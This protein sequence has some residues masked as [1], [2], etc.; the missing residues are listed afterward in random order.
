MVEKKEWH[1]EP[2]SLLDALNALCS[3][4]DSDIDE[5]QIVSWVETL[6]QNQYLTP[7]DLAEISAEEWSAMKLPLR[8]RSLGRLHLWH[9][10]GESSHGR[11]KTKK[12]S[13]SVSGVSSTQIRRSLKN[14]TISGDFKMPFP[15]TKSKRTLADS[16]GSGQHQSGGSSIKVST[17]TPS[18]PN[19]KIVRSK[20]EG[21]GTSGGTLEELSELFAP[22]NPIKATTKGIQKLMDLGSRGDSKEENIASICS[23]GIG[24]DPLCA[25]QLLK[26][27]S[28]QD[29][30]NPDPNK[31][32]LSSLSVCVYNE[33]VKLEILPFADNL[34]PPLVT[35]IVF[36]VINATSLN[37]ILLQFIPVLGKYSDPLLNLTFLV[38]LDANKRNFSDRKHVSV[39]QAEQALKNLRGLAYFEVVDSLDATQF[40]HLASRA[41][42]RNIKTLK[43]KNSN[44]LSK[45]ASL[46]KSCE[47]REALVEVYL[48][49]CKLEFLPNHIVQFRNTLT[50]LKLSH[51]QLRFFPEE[52]MLLDVLEELDL[53]DNLI[54]DLPQQVITHESLTKLDM[55]NNKIFQ[56]SFDFDQISKD[57]VIRL[58][59]NPVYSSIYSKRRKSS[60]ALSQPVLKPVR[61]KGECSIFGRDITEL[62]QFDVQENPHEKLYIPVFVRE[63]V[64][65]IL[66]NGLA[67]AGIFRNE[68]NPFQLADLRERLN[69]GEKIHFNRSD[70]TYG[71]CTLLKTWLKALPK[72]LLGSQ[73]NLSSALENNDSNFELLK[74]HLGTLNKVSYLTLAQLIRVL[75][76]IWLNRDLNM[77]DEETL[78]VGI[79]PC[80]VWNVTE[81]TPLDEIKLESA[82]KLVASMITNFPTLFENDSKYYAPPLTDRPKALGTLY[83]KLESR[84]AFLTSIAYI[85]VPRPPNR[86]NRLW[87]ADE[88]GTINIWN[89]TDFF[90]VRELEVGTE[91]NC[92]VT[93]EETVWVAT[94]DSI[95]TRNGMDGE[96]IQNFPIAAARLLCVNDT[97][98]A[99][100]PRSSGGVICLIDL[101]ELQ[102]KR[103]IPTASHLQDWIFL[104]DQV[105]IGFYD[106]S[107]KV[108]NDQGDVVT[109]VESK[110]KIDSLCYVNCVE[111]VW[112]IGES[113]TIIYNAINYE[114]VDRASLKNSI[115]ITVGDQIWAHRP[116]SDS[117]EIWDVQTKQSAGNICSFH[118]HAICQIVTD[119]KA[120]PSFVYSA[121]TNSLVVWELND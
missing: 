59:G 112:S 57:L 35:V 33:L 62:L 114:L 98:W 79:T 10:P 37:D 20:T 89:V 36:S 9:A 56:L 69:S 52:I 108:F 84:Q 101:D 2:S 107:L 106:G 55:E 63:V 25:D 77:M 40:I 75:H 105:W 80:L 109:D 21:G 83:R 30:T 115:A 41:F 45:L 39:E 54:I 49:R 99:Y 118:N 94:S 27:I 68:P 92:L 91:V 85:S 8:L 103:E 4:L 121:S 64:K 74:E 38:G 93:V 110:D 28:N 17:L 60:L 70:S 13:T 42:V 19:L 119:N 32:K 18:M 61:E 26:L 104:R 15:H 14:A 31:E 47:T 24:G 82:Q 58:K 96:L 90:L 86:Y 102:V 116:S 113:E 6:Q 12:H 111:Q 95:Q 34:E 71:V 100:Y 81:Q 87:S 73:E 7:D 1:P 48:K 53:S 3:L 16:D 117:V 120:K 51:N 66:C 29:P 78:A 44:W 88:K 43:N 97:M 22:I 76:M 23:M 65:F 11:K 67:S 50:R 46:E 72:P 5:K